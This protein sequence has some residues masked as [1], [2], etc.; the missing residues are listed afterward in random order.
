MLD[1][2]AAKCLWPGGSLVA[3]NIEPEKGE[4]D[5]YIQALHNHPLMEPVSIPIGQGL[6]GSARRWS[7]VATQSHN[8][9]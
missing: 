2:P 7:V 9:D 6:E 8:L 3:D 4:S 1:M 5:L